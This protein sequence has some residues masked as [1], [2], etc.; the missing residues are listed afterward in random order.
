MWLDYDEF[1]QKSVAEFAIE[2]LKMR[3]PERIFRVIQGK[4]WIVQ[5]FAA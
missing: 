3:H 2:Q 1:P 4:S 5:Y